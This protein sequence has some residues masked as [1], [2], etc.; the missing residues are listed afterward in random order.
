MQ[1]SV[2]RRETFM[3]NLESPAN[4]LISCGGGLFAD[5]KPLM[6]DIS[7]RY[8]LI[9]EARRLIQPMKMGQL[10]GYRFVG[11][12]HSVYAVHYASMAGLE[13]TEL[14]E[15]FP[16]LTQKH[17]ELTSVWAAIE[18]PRGRRRLIV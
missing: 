8:D 4:G 5:V 9:G 10:K 16:G 13:V 14:Q 7:R 17:L 3:R 15:K 18:P 1:I 11:L 6:A 12:P 2:A